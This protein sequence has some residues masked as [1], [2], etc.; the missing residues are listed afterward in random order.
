MALKPLDDPNAVER[1][2]LCGLEDIIGKVVDS[3]DGFDECRTFRALG[4]GKERWLMDLLVYRW[5]QRAT[6]INIIR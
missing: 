3:G 4:A 1:T 2:S 6:T 5:Q